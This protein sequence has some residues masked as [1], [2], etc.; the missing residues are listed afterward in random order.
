VTG[1]PTWSLSRWISSR[2]WPLVPKPRVNLTRFDG[3]FAPNSTLRAQITPARCGRYAG[4]DAAKT[5][6]QQRVTIAWVQRRLP[7]LTD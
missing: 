4:N 2:A 7:D 3:V 5:P 6:V 1:P